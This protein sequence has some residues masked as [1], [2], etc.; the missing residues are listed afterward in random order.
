[1]I[2]EVRV[3]ENFRNEILFDT[4]LPGPGTFFRRSAALEVGGRDP[5]WKY[6]G[7]YDFWLRLSKLGVIERR[8]GYLACWRTHPLSTSVNQ[9]SEEL[10]TERIAVI[11][12]FVESSDID[13]HARDAAIANA[14][15]QASLLTTHNPNLPGRRALTKSLKI[16][17]SLILRKR[18]FWPK[19][20]FVWMM[21]VSGILRRS[22]LAVLSSFKSK[23]SISKYA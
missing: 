23:R 12:Q 10:F 2:K 18:R 19:A 11:E 20:I 7:D 15:F 6:M 16:S 8:P 1:V 5:K 21:P 4:C 13:V 17:P 22:V 14:Y 9:V 3:Q